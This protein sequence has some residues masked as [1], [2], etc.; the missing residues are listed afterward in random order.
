MFVCA[1]LACPPPYFAEHAA[2]TFTSTSVGS[3]ALFTCYKGYQMDSGQ[4]TQLSHCL[5]DSVWN[6]VVNCNSKSINK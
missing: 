1:D 4:T 2:V 6:P 5:T 3:V